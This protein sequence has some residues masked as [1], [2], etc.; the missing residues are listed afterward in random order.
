[1]RMLEK[2]ATWKKDDGFDRIKIVSEM[3]EHT[4][5][6]LH[7]GFDTE[8]LHTELYNSRWSPTPEEFTL[9][10]NVKVASLR[11]EILLS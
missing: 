5:R 11:L 2:Q 6:R 7:A 4:V 8:P 9:D 10:M 1:M 3:H